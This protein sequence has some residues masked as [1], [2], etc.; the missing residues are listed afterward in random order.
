[1][2]CGAGSPVGAGTEVSPNKRTGSGG[3]QRRSGAGGVHVVASGGG[4]GAQ[5]GYS[6]DGDSDEE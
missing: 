1:M 5:Q 2:V 3:K 4:G 6:S